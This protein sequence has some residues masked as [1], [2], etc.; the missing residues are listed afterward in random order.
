MVDGVRTTSPLRTLLDLC[1]TLPLPAAVVAA[2]SALRRGLV[3]R[4][5]LR[6]ACV[7]LPNGR[8][9]SRVAAVVRLV[10]PASGSVLESL[11]RVLFHLAGLLPPQTQYPYEGRT[12]G[13]SGGSTSRGPRLGWSWRRTGTP[14]TPIGRGT[15][16]TGAGRTRWSWRAGASCAS[17]GRTCATTPSRCSRRSVRRWPAD[18]SHAT[19]CAGA[20]AGQAPREPP[21]WHTC[22]RA[23]RQD[24]GAARSHAG[25]ARG[26]DQLVCTVG[27]KPEDSGLEVQLSR[28]AAA[29]RRQGRVG[30]PPA[31]GPVT[32]SGAA[33]AGSASR[34]ARDR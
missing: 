9:R 7:R 19:R 6:R 17:A 18:G 10:D 34:S 26:V 3:S 14:S 4:A 22:T 1:R 33:A 29:P 30:L 25:E 23:D 20:P 2:D 11:C 12:A 8:E 24:R 32:D 16:P 28:S 5:E 15:A 27:P 21:P 31:G 13:C